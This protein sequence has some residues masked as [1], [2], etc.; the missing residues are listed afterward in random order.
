MNRPLTLTDPTGLQ[1][2]EKVKVTVAPRAATERITY[3]VSGKTD[4]EAWNDAKI[5]SPKKHGG[6]KAG[7]YEFDIRVFT[8]EARGTYITNADGSVTASVT[9]S[10]LVVTVTDKYTVPVWSN[11]GDEGIPDSERKEWD[12]E[13]S[14]LES[15]EKGHVPITD[16]GVKDI[17][18]PA[19]EGL[20]PT[21]GTGSGTG[22]TFEEAK[23]NAF[24]KATEDA[25]KKIQPVINEAIKKIQERHN[26]FESD[27]MN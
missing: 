22:S 5:Q 23:N 11:R 17:L 19:L 24:K 12:D 1:A 27:D 6:P 10:D 8:P 14:R 21:A 26:K 25:M 16:G 3:P 7:R 2:G 15:H 9:V 18:I 20:K 13:S 4:V